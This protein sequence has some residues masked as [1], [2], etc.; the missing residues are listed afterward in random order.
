MDVENNYYEK[1]IVILKIFI[2]KN[3]MKKVIRLKESDLKKIIKRVLNEQVA[4]NIPEPTVYDKCVPF[5]FSH[6]IEKLI[7]EI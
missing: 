2:I 3:T 4:S 7:S 6:A 1:N 5:M